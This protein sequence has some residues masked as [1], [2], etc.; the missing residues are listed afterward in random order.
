M[1]DSKTFIA[2][3]WWLT[4]IILASQEAEIRRIEVRSQL[5]E[6]LLEYQKK[7]PNTKQCWQRSYL[8]RVRL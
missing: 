5:K 8:A 1:V 4:P 2:G 3:H 7:K 6:I